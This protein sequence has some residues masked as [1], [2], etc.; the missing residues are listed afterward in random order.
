MDGATDSTLS[1]YQDRVEAYLAATPAVVPAAVSELLDE[2][3]LHVRGGVVLEL[4]SGP[5]VEAQYLEDRGLRVMR[6]DGTPAFVERLRQSGLDAR[7]LDARS[8]DFGGPFDAVVA[9]AVLLHLDRDDAARALAACWRATRPKG[10]LALT[11]KEGDGEGWSTA[12]L[13][14]P[15]WFVYWRRPDLRD[16]LQLAGWRV[17][18]LD[19]V[20]GRV[21]PWLHA[22]CVR[23]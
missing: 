21:E 17:L 2:L 7:V 19:R 11:L 3:V 18:K 4:G 12:K 10:L 8:D 16:A 22:L 20:Q 1:A 15:R 5:G 13:G 6:T 23:S 14:K 9:N